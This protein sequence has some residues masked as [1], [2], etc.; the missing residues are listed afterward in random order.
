MNASIYHYLQNINSHINNQ[1]TR[2]IRLEQ[3]VVHLTNTIQELQE[4]QP[5]HVGTIE[6]KFDQLKVET[7]EG[8]LNIGLN[9]ANLDAIEDMSVT[10]N[11]QSETVLHP[12]QLEDRKA[13]EKEL[14]H[15]V[16]SEVPTIITK[17]KSDLDLQLDESFTQLIQ[18]DIHKQLPNRITYYEQQINKDQANENNLDRNLMIIDQIKQDIHT[19]IFSYLEKVNKQLKEG[20]KDEF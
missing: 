5:I 17:I 18:T 10:N 7:L 19:A 16:Q 20:K 12:K 13:I 1:E 11:N 2:I 14:T 4:R 8:T 6:Y 15:Y 3:L 9:P